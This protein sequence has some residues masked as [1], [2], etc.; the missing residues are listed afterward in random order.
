[1]LKTSLKNPGLDFS[2]PADVLVPNWSLSNPAAFDLK[3][4]HPLNTYLIL[5]TSLASGNSAEVGEVG[6]HCCQE[7]S[8]V[9]KVGLDMHS[10]SGGDLWWLGM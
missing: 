5:E 2:R 8:D 7:R 10:I 1:M 4:I 3:V 6:K 9:C